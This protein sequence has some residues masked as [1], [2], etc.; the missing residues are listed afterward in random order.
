MS[1]E[2]YLTWGP[3]PVPPGTPDDDLPGSV[4]NLAYAIPLFW[5]ALFD[6]ESIVEIDDDGSRYPA[7]VKPAK[8]AILLS[9][10]RWPRIRGLF[11][12]DFEPRFTTW[13]DFLERKAKAYV[14][15]KT[16][17]LCWMY[18]T[19][20]E[21]VDDLTKCLTAFDH[22]PKHGRGRVVLNERWSYLLGQCYAGFQGGRIVP[23]GAY[24]YWGHGWRPPGEGEDD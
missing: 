10:E 20:Q 16:K 22:V 9:C 13:V 3:S 1:N 12:D 19:R 8:E 5:C 2:T 23:Q 4:L 21:F 7:L 14:I 6:E 18:R 11:D 24:S 17:E 15:C